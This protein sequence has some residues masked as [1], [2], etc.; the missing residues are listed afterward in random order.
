MAKSKDRKHGWPHNDI[1][2]NATNFIMGLLLLL[3]GYGLEVTEGTDL[4]LM[5]YNGNGV[6]DVDDILEHLSF[7]PNYS[8]KTLESKTY[9]LD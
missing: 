6:I 1:Q 4:Y 3:M 9:L 2:M 7:Q 8:E 5:D